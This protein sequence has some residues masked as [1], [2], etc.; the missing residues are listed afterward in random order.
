[1]CPHYAS[2][3]R[4][5]ARAVAA[6]ALAL[7]LASAAP[8]ARAQRRRRVVITEES[9]TAP[10]IRVPYVDRP[11]TT[12]RYHLSLYLGAGFEYADYY[13]N[14]APPS[15]SVWGLGGNFEASFGI[16]DWLEVGAGIGGR[17]TDDARNL[18]LINPERYGR[19][20]REWLPTGLELARPNAPQVL[21]HWWLTNPYGRVR[22]AFLNHAPAFIGLDLYVTAPI[23]WNSCLT[24]DIGVPLHFAIAH[25]VRIETG[26][27]H[28]FVWCE[29]P[30]V[31]GL[32]T[33][34]WSMQVPLRLLFQIV[35][36]FWLGL[37]TGFQ[38]L[39]YRFDD[40]RYI[41][42]PLGIQAGVRLIPRLDLMFQVVAPEFVHTD[43]ITGRNVWLDR[44][45][46]GV[47][48]QAWL[49]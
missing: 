2:G 40:M 29:V 18:G 5:A 41:T 30:P 33:R 22:F 12:T 13:K 48:I 42:I 8:D 7:G 47:A 17:A 25:V 38:T 21:G 11:I 10:A 4:R 6:I 46:T 14:Y 19:V 35:P 27:Y 16:T 1:M 44:I 24:T 36:R 31:Q 28:E 45:G 15:R 49:L 43:P 3:V 9:Y 32:A 23:V 39:G 26:I 34:L 37:L 20:N